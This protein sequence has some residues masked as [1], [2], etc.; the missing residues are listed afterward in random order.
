M[1]KIGLIAF[2]AAIALAGVSYAAQR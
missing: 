1:A 2:A